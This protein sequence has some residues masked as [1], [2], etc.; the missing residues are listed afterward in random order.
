MKEIY[1]LTSKGVRINLIQEPYM[2]L[3]ETD[4]F[5]YKWEQISSGEN[6]P[7]I[8]GMK[9]GFVSPQFTI[10]VSGSTES[11]FANNLENLISAFDGDVYR[12]KMGRLY[13]GN[14]YRNCFI[15]G[16]TFPK[17]FKTKM[18]SVGFTAIS[19]VADWVE[20]ETVEFGGAGD[21]YQTPI[22]N[23]AS[24]L[25]N[26][27]QDS[28]VVEE[29]NDASIQLK[30]TN[31]EP[32]G[33]MLIDFGE[34]K[35]VSS[36]NNL[37]FFK[38]SN[39]P[40]GVIISVSSDGTNYEEIGRV[41]LTTT[42]RQ[43]KRTFDYNEP[44]QFRYLKLANNNNMPIWSIDSSNFA[45]YSDRIITEN[46]LTNED[47]ITLG[48]N[49]E[50]DMWESHMIQFHKLGSLYTPSFIY[51]NAK[52]IDQV[53]LTATQ[54]DAAIMVDAYYDDEWHYLG[55]GTQEVS[56]SGLDIHCERVRIGFQNSEYIYFYNPATTFNAQ[57]V[58]QYTFTNDSYAPSDAI[59]RISESDVPS[60][61]IGE[62]TYGADVVIDDGQFLE[63]DTKEHTVRL[64]EEDGMTYENVYDKRTDGCFEKIESGENSISWFGNAEIEVLLEK[65]RS[66][67]KWN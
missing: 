52:Y 30:W 13:V 11:E 14:N 27:N 49:I 43:T 10:D 29:N 42:Y 47:N 34:I 12:N 4:L 2:M 67:P 32:T 9:K 56:L 17:V 5:D 3:E 59:I 24:Y 51:L 57:G 6:F 28:L 48:E 37:E 58:L 1:Y 62:N 50:I 36:I 16:A 8:K 21:I 26:N 53:H 22:N 38:G 55:G 54:T 64:Y 63:I 33:Y 65:G 66:T 35:N 20:W 44:V 19:D 18:A 40:A 23:L 46:I 39:G 7:K 61:V 60:V 41:D 15:Q 25:P 31:T 45:I